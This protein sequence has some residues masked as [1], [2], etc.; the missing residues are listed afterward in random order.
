MTDIN[1]PATTDVDVETLMGLIR[2]RVHSLPDARYIMG[3]VE[4]AR[5]HADGILR[6]HPLRAGW[7]GWVKSQVSDFVLRAVRL[8][9]RFQ[10]VFNHSVVGVLQLI[11]EDLSAYEKRLAAEG[12]GAQRPAASRFDRAAYEEKYLDAAPYLDSGLAI[13]REL[14]GAGDATLVLD[15]GR[16]ELLAALGAG[17]LK[18]V[19]VEP[20]TDI[21]DYLGGSADESFGGVYAGR[22]AERLTG[23][24]MMWLLELARKRLRRGGVLVASAA[25]TDHLPALRKFY[26]DPSLVRPVPVRLME[27]M[28][29][30]SGFDVR[31]F[32]FSAPEGGGGGELVETALA[33]EVYP[34][35]YYTVAAVR[36]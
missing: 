22:V 28:L 13:F 36:G 8:N 15:C 9:F 3:E 6:P 18:A 32:R 23:E 30:R 26:M 16:G 17:G 33:R 14:S 1:S 2:R 7:K 11:A 21:F 29:E 34:Y 12:R 27:F 35:D 25:N 31:H 5:L 4:K 19:V 20:G 10:E 24:R